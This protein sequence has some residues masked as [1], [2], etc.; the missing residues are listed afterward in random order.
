[1]ALWYFQRRPQPVTIEFLSTQAIEEFMSQLKETLRHPLFLSLYAPWLLFAFAYG[2]LIPVLPLYAAGFEVSY[3]LIGVVLAGEALGQLAGDI[4]AGL[5]LRRL[6]N[7]RLMIAG[8]A[9]VALSTAALF[10]AETIWLVFVLRLVA[11]FG[12]AMAHLAQHAYL[13]GAVSLA[14]RGRASALYGG[15]NRVGT[16]TGPVVGGFVAASAGLRAPFLIFAVVCM[17]AALIVALYLRG[18]DGDTGD[19]VAAHAAGTP[20]GLLA[21]LRAH[22]QI[23]AAAGSGQIFAQMIRAGRAVILPLYG[24]DV[25]GL[26]VG[27]IGLV[28]GLVAAMDMSLFYLAGWLMDRFGRKYA[29][30][31]CFAIQ[32]IGMALI[33]LAGDFTGLLLAGLVIGLGNGLGSGTMIALGSDLAPREAQGEFLGLWRLIGD[34]GFTGGPLVIG[35]VAD[36]LLLQTA[37]LVIAGAGFL[38]AGIFAFGVPETLKKRA[39]AH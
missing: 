9:L 4:P 8:L 5:L 32:G 1:V 20:G 34:A 6:G 3:G 30:V 10:L 13:A 2:L 35:G 22:F 12:R 21:T 14:R 26:D 27:A 33:P 25:L 36:L 29:I 18:A 11:G 38:A 24:A 16:F 39:P 28:V 15:V 37:P 17:L 7:R 23:L 31:P 19:E